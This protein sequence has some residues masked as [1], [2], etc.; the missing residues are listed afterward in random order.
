MKRIYLSRI[1]L[2]A[3]LLGIASSAFP[4]EAASSLSKTL[5]LG[6][7]DDASIALASKSGWIIG[8][9][10]F[11]S[12]ESSTVFPEKAI[13]G[14]DIWVT[15]LDA[16]LNPLWSHRM[17]TTR[18]D[19]AGRATLDLTG[20]IWIVGTSQLETNTATQAVMTASPPPSMGPATGP[21]TAPVTVNPDGVSLTSPLVAAPAALSQLTIQGLRNDGSLLLKNSINFGEKYS[22]LPTGVVSDTAGLWIA[23]TVLTLETKASRGFYLYC[24][25][26]LQCKAP[27]YLGKSATSIRTV[28]LNAGNLV[29]AGSTNDLWKGKP[30]IGKVDALALFIN[31]K[32]GV[33]TQIQRS[34]NSGTRR[35]WE[36]SA[37][38]SGEAVLAGT[39][40]S[41]KKLEIVTTTFTKTGT[42]ASTGRWLGASRLALC[43][44]NA[45]VVAL[46]FTVNPSELKVLAAGAKGVALDSVVVTLSVS[47][48]GKR[49]LTSAQFAP[50]AGDQAL[51]AM[52]ASSSVIML[53]SGSTGGQILLD[54]YP[55]S[56]SG[57]VKR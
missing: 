53:V 30:A 21:A 16:S 54:L 51:L 22:V 50:R 57:A 24:D 2:V 28:S 15:Q 36:S 27:I 6:V 46:G 14:S 40:D 23:G 17:G 26:A 11:E 4:A 47:K 25:F 1:A 55:D 37:L 42:V 5:T 44:R 43:P 8:G 38:I 13:G 29:L 45:G 31:S 19:L 52:A 34:G 48:G 10:T 20:N 33:I 9:T 18:D 49:T 7:D 56:G 3:A 39:V 12:S 41:G 35:S 32:S